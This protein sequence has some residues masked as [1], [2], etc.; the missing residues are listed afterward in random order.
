MGEKNQ[1]LR[2]CSSLCG[3]Y[4]PQSTN[5]LFHPREETQIKERWGLGEE[6]HRERRKADPALWQAGCKDALVYLIKVGEKTLLSNCLLCLLAMPL[7]HIICLFAL[8]R[9]LHFLFTVGWSVS[10]AVFFFPPTDLFKC[11]EL[12]S[13]QLT[14][15]TIIS[16]SL[17]ITKDT[18][19]TKNNRSMRR[20]RRMWCHREQKV[21]LTSCFKNNGFSVSWARRNKFSTT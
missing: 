1:S 15:T 10:K 3:C 5:N 17:L 4:P 9:C 11:A 2:H 7:P 19:H 18:Y 16:S 13:S 20:I 21:Q 14:A 12:L 8:M 6:R